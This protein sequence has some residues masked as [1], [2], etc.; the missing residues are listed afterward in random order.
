MVLVAIDVT[1]GAGA[2]PS[3]LIMLRD[4]QSPS[5]PAH[6]LLTVDQESR[7]VPNRG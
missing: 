1:Y 3:M 4:G 2:V 5:G 6:R 7:P